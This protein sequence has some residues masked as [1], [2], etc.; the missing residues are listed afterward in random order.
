MEEVSLKH[1][2]KWGGTICQNIK[3]STLTQI[4]SLVK[5]ST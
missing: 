4:P 5:L 1:K 3:P 2:V